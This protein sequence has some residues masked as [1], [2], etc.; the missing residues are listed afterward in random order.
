MSNILKFLCTLLLFVVASC[1]P[2]ECLRCDDNYLQG[3]DYTIVTLKNF[4]KN[5]DDSYLYPIFARKQEEALI[6]P[7]SCSPDVVPIGTK[8][9]LLQVCAHRIS[10][11]APIIPI[12]RTCMVLKYKFK[13]V[14]NGEIYHFDAL[15]SNSFMKDKGVMFSH[16]SLLIELALKEKA[17]IECFSLIDTNK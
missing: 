3:K 12:R 2:V 8:L 16:G 14:K 6:N 9:K 5:K 1:K 15:A 4:K 11:Y 7:S 13:N 17:F 10:I